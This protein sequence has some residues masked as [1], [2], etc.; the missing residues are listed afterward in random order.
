MPVNGG[1]D[2][3]LFVSVGRWLRASVRRRQAPAIRRASEDWN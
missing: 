1:A 2:A 3:M